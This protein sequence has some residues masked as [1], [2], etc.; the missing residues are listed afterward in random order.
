MIGNRLL[1]LIIKEALL[2]VKKVHLCVLGLYAFPSLLYY[3]TFC[4]PEI[5]GNINLNYISFATTFLLTQS[6]IRLPF[7]DVNTMS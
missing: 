5:H 1:N 7:K 4:I 6:F 2:L 3:F